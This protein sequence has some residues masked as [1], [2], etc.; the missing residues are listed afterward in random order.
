MEQLILFAIIAIVTS[1]FGKSKNKEQ[2]QMPTFDKDAKPQPPVFTNTEEQK[3]QR[4]TIN[5]Q[6]FED[7]ARKFL[8]DI[9]DEQP[10]KDIPKK[11]VQP[12]EIE[13]AEQTPSYVAPPFKPTDTH[14]RKIERPSI[15]RMATGK[16]EVQETSAHQTFALPTSKKALMQAVV[17]AEVLGP[18]KAK[19]K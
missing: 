7:F 13:V 18:P 9:Q 10:Q 17:M 5:T 19:R 16:K 14:Q 1:L 12:V 8:G 4:P 11:Y 2:K 6:S 15:G 3:H